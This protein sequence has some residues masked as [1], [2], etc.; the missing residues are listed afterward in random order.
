MDLY[1][2]TEHLVNLLRQEGH[3]TLATQIA[4]SI[5]YSATGTEILMQLQYYL[6]A[7]LETSADYSAEIVSLAKNIHYKIINTL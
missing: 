1:K 7:V 2:E 5:K 6:K 3:L 4:D